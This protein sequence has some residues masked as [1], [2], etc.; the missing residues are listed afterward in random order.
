MSSLDLLRP[1]QAPTSAPPPTW[2]PAPAEPARSSSDG[3]ALTDAQ[4]EA[5]Q[6]AAAEAGMGQTEVATLGAFGLRPSEL[7]PDAA[8]R[9][10]LGLQRLQA[11]LAC[12][13][14]KSTACELTGPGLVGH[15]QSET[16]SGET[17]DELVVGDADFTL[18]LST[19]TRPDG[20]TER[21]LYYEDVDGTFLSGVS[22]EPIEEIPESA[23]SGEQAA[24][25]SEESF[26]SFLEGAL[27]GDFADNDSWSAVAGQTVV[28]FIPVV[29][30]IADARDTV[31][32]IRDVA[33]GKDGAWLRLAAA[34]IGWIPGLGDLA[35]DGL[36]GVRKLGTEVVEDGAERIAKE[37]AAEG[38]QR[39][40][41]EGAEEGA[42]AAAEVR[43]TLPSSEPDPS[44][45]PRGT[46]TKRNPKDQAASSVRGYGRENESAQTLA[47]NG[48]DVE[49]NPVVDGPKRPD[50]RIEGEIFDNYAPSTPRPRNI[51]KEVVRKV[52]EE[53]TERVV[54]NL[55]DSPVDLDA[56]TAQFAAWPIEGL[57][58]VLVVRGEQVIHFYP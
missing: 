46:P 42:Q 39:L 26:S 11:L 12:E 17:D 10:T 34:G 40:V 3:G 5:D 22:A 56:L 18:R 15:Q 21:A 35:K 19:R 45:T 2:A 48:Y 30:Q 14:G 44:A 32:A 9:M 29:G 49:Q 7:E 23:P 24:A 1:Q 16:V 43:R 6:V 36:R 31:A 53:Q 47:R 38:E 20:T 13:D 55:D 33:E 37:A 50:Y 57:Q 8:Q 4:R 25:A 41:R 28:S 58:E 51:W 52:D 54:L 27:L